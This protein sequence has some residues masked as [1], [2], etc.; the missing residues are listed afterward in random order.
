AGG[1]R[2]PVANAIDDVEDRHLHVAG[3]EE[4]R[5]QR[6]HGA[7]RGNR[8]RRRH[9]RLRGDLPAEHALAL[10]VRIVPAK[11]VDL[12]L[13]DVE[14][15]E[16]FVEQGMAQKLPALTSWWRSRRR[17]CRARSCRS[18]RSRGTSRARSAARS[19]RRTCRTSPCLRRSRILPGSG[20]RPACVPLRQ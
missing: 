17:E 5:M 13:L 10:L 12:E 7:S 15:P 6:V 2:T 14:E 16:Y 9:Q 1:E 11:D 19:S 8:A 20:A 4:V 3:P 18:T